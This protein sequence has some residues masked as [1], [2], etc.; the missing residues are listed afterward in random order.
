MVVI[1]SKKRSGV[2]LEP[3][4]TEG[5]VTSDSDRNILDSHCNNRNY[6][7]DRAY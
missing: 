5:L 3:Q 1:I 4:L 7:E 6:G 2:L